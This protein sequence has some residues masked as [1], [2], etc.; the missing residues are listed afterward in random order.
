[1]YDDGLS[2]GYECLNFASSTF[3]KSYTGKRES[4][5]A[6]TDGLL[7]LWGRAFEPIT[8]EISGTSF[9]DLW[10][11]VPGV[12]TRGEPPPPSLRA[13]LDTVR[14]RVEMPIVDKSG[15]QGLWTGPTARRDGAEL[16]DAANMACQRG[17][18]LHYI[19]EA[20]GSTPRTKRNFC[21]NIVPSWCLLNGEQA[22]EV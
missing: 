15:K 12:P 17:T 21:T 16:G 11:A 5:L 19:L 3:N 13:N 20:G 8:H 10:Q 4:E 7:A 18:L 6:H 22:F 14:P 2:R 9:G 1:M